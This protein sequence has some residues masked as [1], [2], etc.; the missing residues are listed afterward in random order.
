MHFLR[1]FGLVTKGQKSGDG[2]TMLVLPRVDVDFMASSRVIKGKAAA[3]V[4]MLT[5]LIQLPVKL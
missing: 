4:A 1:D 3:A 5:A 2:A